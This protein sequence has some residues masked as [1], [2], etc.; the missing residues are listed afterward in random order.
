MRALNHSKN[1]NNPNFFWRWSKGAKSSQAMRRSIVKASSQNLYGLRCQR[2][3]PN[4]FAVAKSLVTVRM[5]RDLDQRPETRDQKF[6]PA[7][8]G[9][10]ARNIDSCNRQG[11]TIPSA[12]AS[13]VSART[14]PATLPQTT[15]CNSGPPYCG[16]TRVAL[17]IKRFLYNLCRCK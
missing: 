16:H 2:N 10:L 12:F 13:I 5:C 3:T 7:K 6:A 9:R 1:T 8:Q 14:Q 15:I 17:L 11:A 4:L